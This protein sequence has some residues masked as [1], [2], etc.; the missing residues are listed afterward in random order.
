MCFITIH[1]QTRMSQ[2]EK[3]LSWL[4]MQADEISK[5]CQGAMKILLCPVQLQ[6]PSVL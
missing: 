2:L 4:S 1:G 6:E 5:S 3:F